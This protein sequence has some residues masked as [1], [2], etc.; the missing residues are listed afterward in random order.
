MKLGAD[1]IAINL[2]STCGKQSHFNRFWQG[3]FFES[4][5][6][7]ISNYDLLSNVLKVFLMNSIYSAFRMCVY[8][9][10]IWK[11]I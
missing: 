8:K 6:E 1:P 7:M 11:V 10:F 2:Q 9:Q 5:V 4:I 3:I